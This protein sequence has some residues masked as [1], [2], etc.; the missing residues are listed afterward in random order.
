MISRYLLAFMLL[1]SLFTTSLGQETAATCNT[2]SLYGIVLS[3]LSA[4]PVPPSWV[5]QITAQGIG[6]GPVLD[7][8]ESQREMYCVKVPLF[9]KVNLVFERS[10]YDPQKI[11]QVYADPRKRH[12]FPLPVIKLDPI[13][14]DQ[15]GRSANTEIIQEIR[16]K[17]KTHK[18]ALTASDSN[19]IFIWNLELYRNTYRGKPEVIAEIDAFVQELK[20]DPKFLFFSTTEFDNKSTV[21]RFIVARMLNQTV[22]RQV[23][24]ADIAALINDSRV[25]A[26][27]R[28]EAINVLSSLRDLTTNEIAQIRI[29]LMKAAQDDNAVVVRSSATKGLGHFGDEGTLSSL[30]KIAETDDSEE[31]RLEARSAIDTIKGSGEL[32]ATASHFPASPTYTIVEYPENKRVNVRLDPIGFTEGRGA[33]NILRNSNG[34]RIKLNVSNIPA[35]VDSLM[36]Y[37]VYEN[38]TIARLGPIKIREGVGRYTAITPSARFMLI[39]SA[40]KNL[41]R[42]DAAT[43]V[44]FRSAVP[45]GFAVIPKKAPIAE[46]TAVGEIVSSIYIPPPTEYSVPMLGLPPDPD[47]RPVTLD[48]YLKGAY[49]QTLSYKHVNLVLRRERSNIDLFMQIEDLKNVPGGKVHTLWAVLDKLYVRLGELRQ[50]NGLSKINGTVPF[51]DFGLLLTAEDPSSLTAEPSGDVV[52]VVVRRVT[53]STPQ[54]R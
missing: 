11:D 3:S 54:Q 14:G 53:K 1:F 8:E 20:N 45:D 16:A 2:T 40:E 26:G 22:E 27:I 4:K 29:A 46:R 23:K 51:H 21:F 13:T 49:D 17:L 34:T 24:A 36:A 33:A 35:G 12:S 18:D 47:D 15:R 30:A 41:S 31:V 25:F 38:G 50:E 6:D 52:A 7:K 37:A 19:D 10:G 39:V 5:V 42:Y 28:S 43:R 44:F 32:I 9:S 48:V